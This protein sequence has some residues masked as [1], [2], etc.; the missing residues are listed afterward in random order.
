MLS[1]FMLA[2]V[3]V[4]FP[5]CYS[6]NIFFI[7]MVLM[8]LTNMKTFIHSTSE[9]DWA[10]VANRLIEKVS[11]AL[12]ILLVQFLCDFKEINLDSNFWNRMRQKL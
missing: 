5:S 7:Y 10:W 12:L 1:C 8:L 6:L 2:L 9:M 3:P 4:I 11:T